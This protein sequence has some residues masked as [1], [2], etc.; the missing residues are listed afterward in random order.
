MPKK[1]YNAEEILVEILFPMV[2]APYRFFDQ[3]VL[4][5]SKLGLCDFC[6]EIVS[7]WRPPLS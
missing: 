6:A 5:R 4:I 7:P 2:R 1:R 3:S